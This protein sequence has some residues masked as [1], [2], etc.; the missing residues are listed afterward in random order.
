MGA[1]SA[2]RHS[3]VCG[4]DSTHLPSLLQQHCAGARIGQ[5]LKLVRLSTRAILFA[6]FFMTNFL[7]AR[8]SNSSH[9]LGKAGSTNM[10]GAW[11]Q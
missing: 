5:L 8:S 10:Q 9:E 2:R 6:A 1:L 4:S 3:A 11:F 7:L